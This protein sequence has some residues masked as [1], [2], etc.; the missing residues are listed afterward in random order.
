MLFARLRNGLTIL[1]LT[2]ISSV[3]GQ[4]Y[5]DY[6]AVSS[7][8]WNN[9]SIWRQWDGTGWNTLPSSP[10]SSSSSTTYILSGNSVTLA[11]TG[12][13]SCG[14][15]YIEPGGRLFSNS[16]GTLVHLYVWG[17]DIVCDGEIGRPGLNDGISLNIEGPS[18]TISGS[19]SVSAARLLKST[20]VNTTTHLTIATDISLRWESINNSVLYNATGAASFFNVTLQSGR[21]LNCIGGTLNPGSVAIDGFKSASAGDAAGTFTINGTLIVAGILYVSNTNTQAGYTCNFII[22]QGGVIKANQINSVSS[23]G[24]LTTFTVQ[25]EGRLELTGPLGL[26]TDSSLT[27]GTG[28]NRYSFLPGSTVIYS[29]AAAQRIAVTGD[30]NNTTQPNNQYW[31]LVL[32]GS[33]TKTIKAGT[34]NVRGNL[35]VIGSAVLDQ[36]QNDPDINIGGDWNMHSA[37]AFL[38]STDPSRSVRF[39]GSGASPGTPVQT[40]T[41]PG[42]ENFHNLW[43]SKSVNGAVRFNSPVTVRQQ[44][45]LGAPGTSNFGIIDLNRQPLTI[46]KPVPAAIRLAGTPGVYRFIISEDSSSSHSGEVRWNIGNTSAALPGSSWPWPYMIPFGISSSHDTL[47]F[48]FSKTSTDYMGYLS[49]STYGTTENNLPW[50]NGVTHLTSNVYTNNSPDNRNWT[51]DRYWWIGSSQPAA[52]L[53][54]AFSYNRKSGTSSEAPQNDT[55]PAGLKAQYWSNGRWNLPAAGAAF[56]A[57]ST[58]GVTNLPATNVPWTLTSTQSPLGNCISGTSYSSATAF[59]SYNWNG[60]IFTQSGTYAARF[61]GSGGCDSIAQLS[62]TVDTASRLSFAFQSPQC[63]GGSDGA[64]LL[65]T[66]ALPTDSV[67]YSWS[68]GSTLSTLNGITAGSYSVVVTDRNQCA[69]RRNLQLTEPAQLSPALTSSGNLCP[70]SSDG[71]IQLNISGGVPPYSYLW[72]NG[73]TAAQLSGL[74]PGTYSVTTTDANGCDTTATSVIGLYPLIHIDSFSPSSGT[75]GD[76]LT[77]HGQ[78]FT[79][80]TTVLFGNSA[81]AFNVLNDSTIRAIVPLSPAVCSITVTSAFSCTAVSATSFSNANGDAVL[82]VRMFLEGFY[83]QGTMVPALINRGVGSSLTAVDTVYGAL[84]DTVDGTILACSVKSIVDINGYVDFR[85]P[86]QFIGSRH[87][88]LVGN[89]H[90]IRTWSAQPLT[91]GTAGIYDFTDS[92][93]KAYGNNLWQVSPGTWALYTGDLNQD[94]FIDP[95]DFQ[96]FNDDMLSF[97]TGYLQSDLNGDG[98]TD[99]FDFLYVGLNQFAFVSALHP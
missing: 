13:Y 28:N 71:N 67:T 34:L 62:L 55:L 96:I 18:C 3:S 6:A 83:F 27:W 85:F 88:L 32:G 37:G 25:S 7:G 38:E 29:A 94:D 14:N 40:I 53:C 41:C 2:A 45:T 75:T 5:N 54:A 64:I 1:L 31:N 50:P 52:G 74:T 86:N 42:G 99:N 48:G 66:S 20:T 30:F 73:A 82:R 78:G 47:P 15:L 84:T 44:L 70:G 93:S 61:T 90:S 11:G 87:Y 36:E 24:I 97:A 68:N 23:N 49:V 33:G 10:P 22:G 35:T 59:C 4:N 12:P 56:T 26:A 21:L 89:G 63:H 57:G 46:E 58:V 95:F 60:N 81:A 72:S 98:A 77:L 17:Y 43:I 76:T 19:G 51:A 16:T 69:V 39:N 92:P 79:G 65:T 91:I 8:A 80:S 9:T